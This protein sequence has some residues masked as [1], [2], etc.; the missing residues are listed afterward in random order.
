[1]R[2]AFGIVAAAIATLAS[3]SIAHAEDSTVELT[4]SHWVPATFKPV[5]DPMQQWADSIE[6]ASDGS[7]KITIF[8]GGQLGAAKDHYDMAAN[9]VADITWLVPGYT[10]GRFPLISLIELPFTVTDAEQGSAALHTWYKDY[11]EMEMPE[12]KFLY[13]HLNHFGTWH[14]R[15]D[16]RIQVPGDV[17]GMKVRPAN[18]TI[19][20][21][22]SELGGATV[23]MPA[24]E[25][26]EAVAKGAVDGIT[27]QWGSLRAFGID[28]AAKY[29]IDD[30]F[31]I[32]AFTTVMNKEAYAE[33]SDAQKAV[34]DAHTTPEW[35]ARI[36]GFW[37]DWEA[38]GREALIN[39][40]GHEV[41]DLT[42]EQ[43]DEWRES[44][45]FLQTDWQDQVDG[46][47]D[48]DP[49]EVRDALY[50]ELRKRDAL[51]GK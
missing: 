14:T 39:A 50:S 35:A 42:P 27:L 49:G 11:A 12:V 10:P 33:L 8:P 38:E 3:A 6:E 32:V 31:Y 19:A 45:E 37:A 20:R 48:V 5:T 24:P 23:Q 28:K 44:A 40:D 34:I 16:N 2:R 22:V 46:K 18:Q 7:I 43:L 15:G 36:G 30:K 4:M 9:G 29:H 41:Y 26:R 1:M 47:W 21:W 17:Q 25:A 51:Y 13:A